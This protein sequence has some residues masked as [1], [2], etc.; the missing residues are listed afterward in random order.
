MIS[1]ETLVVRADGTQT[2]E[3]REYPDPPALP[4]NEESPENAPGEE[5][6]E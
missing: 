6:A 1:L 3:M 2:R 5:T 4:E